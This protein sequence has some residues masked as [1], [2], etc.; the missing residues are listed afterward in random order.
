MC[1]GSG[2]DLTRE[3]YCFL[4]FD[5]LKNMYDIGH[6]YVPS[7]GWSGVPGSIPGKREIL[8]AATLAKVPNRCFTHHVV[9]HYANLERFVPIQHTIY[10]NFTKKCANRCFICKNQIPRPGT[11]SFMG[12]GVRFLS[13]PN[14]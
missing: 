11:V 3:S 4:F 14:W 9:G 10:I 1:P 2:C 7:R 13:H 8:F 12:G 5:D 6:I